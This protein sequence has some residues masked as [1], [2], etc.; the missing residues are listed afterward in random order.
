QCVGLRLPGRVQETRS[1]RGNAVAPALRRHVLW[2]VSPI[3]AG[4]AVGV[5][6]P[7][8]VPRRLRIRAAPAPSRTTRTAGAA[9]SCVAY[10]VEWARLSPSGPR[11]V[12]RKSPPLSSNTRNRSLP[13]RRGQRRAVGL[14]GWRGTSLSRWPWPTAFLPFW[15]KTSPGKREELGSLSAPMSL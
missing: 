6:L 2:F 7:F 12:Q 14:A 15:L 8:P 3:A 13:I 5:Q 1:D 11:T 4:A 9:S 10:G